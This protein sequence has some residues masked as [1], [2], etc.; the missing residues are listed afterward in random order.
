MRR[1][2]LSIAVPQQN[3]I[4]LSLTLVHPH[5]LNGQPAH[6]PTR[7]GDFFPQLQKAILCYII[8]RALGKGED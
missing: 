2:D 6:K 8:D 4:F 3:S 1:F 7:L 5:V